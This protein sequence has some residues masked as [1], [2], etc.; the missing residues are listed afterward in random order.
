[1]LDFLA[2]KITDDQHLQ[3]NIILHKTSRISLAWVCTFC[4]LPHSLCRLLHHHHFLRTKA[5]TAFSAS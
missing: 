4:T 5:A 2:V 1:M 3:S